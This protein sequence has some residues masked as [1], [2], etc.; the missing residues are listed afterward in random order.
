M[1]YAQGDDQVT[2][3]RATAYQFLSGRELPSGEIRLPAKRPSAQM[4]IKCSVIAKPFDISFASI[5]G[6]NPSVGAHQYVDLQDHYADLRWPTCVLANVSIDTTDDLTLIEVRNDFLLS[7]RELLYSKLADNP[8]FVADDHISKRPCYRRSYVAASNLDIFRARRPHPSE[9][10]HP[11]APG[12]FHGPGLICLDCKMDLVW[13]QIIPFPSVTDIATDL[14]RL[15]EIVQD[16]RLHFN[17]YN[18]LID[19]HTHLDRAKTSGEIAD[20][21]AAIRSAASGVDPLLRFHCK[22]HSVSFPSR[23]LPF[24]QKIEDILARTGMPSDKAVSPQGMDCL[25]KLY[26]ARNSM[27]EGDRYFN[28]GGVRLTVDYHLAE[29][30]VEAAEQFAIWLILSLNGL[31]TCRHKVGPVRCIDFRF[32][33]IVSRAQRVG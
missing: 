9:H 8:L 14:P 31:R 17:S 22:L 7:I 27:H 1:L 28:D 30:F 11:T 29:Q 12:E 6:Q 33:I 3:H 25:A 10:Y 24:D 21:K 26:R 16:M 15:R 4:I 13:S 20:I 18:E 32:T 19:A 5:S 23:S 2:E